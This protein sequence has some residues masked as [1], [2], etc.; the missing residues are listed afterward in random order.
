MYWNLITYITLLRKQLNHGSTFVVLFTDSI[1]ITPLTTQVA[2]QLGTIQQCNFSFCNFL[3]RKPKIKNTNDALS[4]QLILIYTLFK[5]MLNMETEIC[6]LQFINMEGIFCGNILNCQVSRSASESWLRWQ[7]QFSTKINLLDF[8][9]SSLK[10]RKLL[11]PANEVWGKVIFLHLFVILFTVGGGMRGCS[12]GH[13]WLLRGG[14]CG[15]SGGGM[16]GCS[17]GMC[18]CS[19]GGMHGCS[20]GHV[21]LLWGGCAW[22]LRGGACMVARGACVVAQGGMCGCSWGGAWFFRGGPAWFFPWDTVNERAVRILL[23]CIL[24]NKFNCM[25]WI[26]KW[27]IVG[28]SNMQQTTKD[29]YLY[30][31]IKICRFILLHF[32][33][34]ILQIYEGTSKLLIMVNLLAQSLVWFVYIRC[35]YF[36]S[37]S[38]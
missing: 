19:G 17:G 30:E 34:Y 9:C 18:G 29:C 38:W 7:N 13:A 26:E 2:L 37:E 11:P 15:C 32:S 4:E 10:T 14:V 1:Q 31:V 35:C 25:I 28:V 23:E 21:W 33:Q 36:L 24:V 20:G 22:L 8:E 5:N 3:F 12:G 16:H 27:N 6:W